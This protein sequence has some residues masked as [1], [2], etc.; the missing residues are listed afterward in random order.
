MLSVYSLD[1]MLKVINLPATRLLVLENVNYTLI[2]NYNI[3]WRI[4]VF[5]GGGRIVPWPP[6][7]DGKFF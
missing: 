3:Q 6:L 4:C 1:G 2:K 7:A 5:R